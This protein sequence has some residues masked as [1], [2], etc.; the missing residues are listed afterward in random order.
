MII[1]EYIKNTIDYLETKKI[2]DID[3]ETKTLD[4]LIETLILPP[5]IDGNNLIISKWREPCIVSYMGQQLPF[6][7]DPEYPNSVYLD[8]E[9]YEP[10]IDIHPKFVKKLD[11]QL[12][13]TIKELDTKE[14][15]VTSIRYGDDSIPL[16]FI[17]TDETDSSI[18]SLTTIRELGKETNA[19]P[20]SL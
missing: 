18:V 11:K 5:T 7:D 6:R 12:R 16:E 2:T 14:V 20:F 17:K 1:K 13:I 8:Q 3:F 19:E 4:E 10:K 15:E 9:T